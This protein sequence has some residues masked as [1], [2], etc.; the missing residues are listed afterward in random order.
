MQKYSS[1]S[2]VIRKRGKGYQI[3]A[4]EIASFFE[5]G[6]DWTFFRDHPVNTMECDGGNEWWWT[7][8]GD[9]VHLTFQWGHDNWPDKPT[10]ILDKKVFWEV[11]ETLGKKRESPT[12]N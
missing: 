8:I 1:V 3:L 10:A 4:E 11:I 5:K 2:Q 6:G 9:E 12:K 7:E